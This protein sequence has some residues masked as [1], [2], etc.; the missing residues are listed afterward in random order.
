[1]AKIYINIGQS[2]QSNSGEYYKTL[3]F[4]G[5]GGNAF[6]YRVLCTSGFNRGI[7]FVLKLQYNLSTTSR[8]IRFERES[9]FLK[10]GSHPA[11]LKLYDD[12]VYTLPSGEIYPFIITS[13]LPKTL[14]TCFS[15][16]T[17]DFIQKAKCSCQLISAVAYLQSQ[18]VLHRDIK[19]NNIFINNNDV[20]LGDFGLIKKIDESENEDDIEMIKDSLMANELPD[21]NIQGYL[22]MARFYRTLELVAY[23]NKTSPLRMESDIFQLGLVLTE[24]FTGQNPLQP[25]SDLLS[26]IVLNRIGY[27]S[28]NESFGRKV[29]FILC[30]MLELDYRKRININKLLEKF[31]GLYERLEGFEI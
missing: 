17:L 5:N 13:F 30:S 16:G 27:V 25:T 28:G 26:P 18:Q 3:E 22:A 7:I 23:A 14:R 12:G 19:P 1:M 9:F 4:L 24:M 11:I 2:I 21:E 6:A 29:F 31:T 10:N 8:R 15:E 20:A